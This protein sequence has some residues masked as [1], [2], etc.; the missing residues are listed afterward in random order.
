MDDQQY[1]RLRV[2]G[3]NLDLAGSPAG[4]RALASTLREGGAAVTVPMRN[5]SVRQ[6]RGDGALVIE[7]RPAPTLYLRG[8][9]SA[10]EE[11]WAALEAVAG[12][13]PEEGAAAPHRHV[14]PA[15]S[16]GL[17]V[18]LDSADPLAELGL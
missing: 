11:V 9:D 2:I 6:E 8:S 1:C 4:L 15:G 12:A 7:L 16:R 5:G 3:E 14:E 10:L 13:I 18:T 17:V